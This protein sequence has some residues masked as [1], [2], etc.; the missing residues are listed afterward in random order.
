[1]QAARSSEA[2]ADGTGT[3]DEADVA[4]MLA[5]DGV[6]PQLGM[7]PPEAIITQKGLAGIFGKSPKSVQRWVEERWLPQPIQLGEDRCWLVEV[8]VNYLKKRHEKVERDRDR[9]ERVPT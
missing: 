1:M 6:Y 5:L 8:I 7:L 9:A 2:E 4:R 3:G